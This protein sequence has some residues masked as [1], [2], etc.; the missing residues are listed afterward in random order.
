MTKELQS[1]VNDSYMGIGK[2]QAVGKMSLRQKAYWNS[3]DIKTRIAIRNGTAS[4]M[5]KWQLRETNF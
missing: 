1:N 2:Y 4:G 5:S 3:L